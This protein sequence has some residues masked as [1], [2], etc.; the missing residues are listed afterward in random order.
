[1]LTL[2]CAR[3]TGHL[4]CLGSKLNCTLPLLTCLDQAES[5]RQ[6]SQQALFA[7]AALQR[8]VHFECDRQATQVRD[9]VRAQE[10]EAGFLA[11]VRNDAVVAAQVAR[12]NAVHIQLRLLPSVLLL[13][14]VFFSSLFFLRV[15]WISLPLA[16]DGSSRRAETLRGAANIRPVA[17]RRRV[18]RSARVHGLCRACH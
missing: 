8:H 1:M 12:R 18:P 3:G 15:S 7:N 9:H 16:R 13:I 14:C 10:R 4:G 5:M 6:A 17:R 11:M 2:F